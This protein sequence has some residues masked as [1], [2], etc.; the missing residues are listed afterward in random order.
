LKKLRE[1][2]WCAVVFALFFALLPCCAF[3]EAEESGGWYWLTSDAKYSKYFAPQDVT[4]VK[5]LNVAGLSRAVPT[6]IHGW[7]KTGFSYEGAQET[8]SNYG[9]KDILPNPAALSY[10]L[11]LVEVN[12]QNRTLRYLEEDFY[13]SKGNVIWSNHTPRSEKEMN[14][15]QFDETFYAAIVDV[16]FGMDELAR[17]TSPARWIELWKARLPGGG[18]ESAIA[19][20]STMRIKGEQLFYWEWVTKKDAQ[21]NTEEVEFRKRVLNVPMGTVSTKDGKTWTAKAGWQSLEETDLTFHGIPANSKEYPGLL[22]LR[23]YT[24]ENLAWLYRASLEPEGERRILRDA[25]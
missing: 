9:I 11:A 18:E 22:R 6:V 20:T 7:V 8:I 15:Q 4:V 21:G 23:D 2:L 5:S 12:P 14:S 25:D 24:A 13:D 10:S 16:V 19:D 1:K 3:A 17:L